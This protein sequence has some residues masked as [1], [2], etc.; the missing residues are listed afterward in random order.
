MTEMER[1]YYQSL[2]DVAAKVNSA[3]TPEVILQF[4]AKRIAKGQRMFVDAAFTRQDDIAT[5]LSLWIE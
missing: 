1:D 4:I 2:Y 3:G 5:H